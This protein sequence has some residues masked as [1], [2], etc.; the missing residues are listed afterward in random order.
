MNGNDL[1]VNNTP[2]YRREMKKN[3][4]FYFYIFKERS[5][6]MEVW[7]P[8]KN[9]PIYNGSSEGRII[10]IRTQKI[11]KPML[12]KNGSV[13]VHLYK[14]GKRHS[15][16]VRRVIAETFLGEHPGM[17]VRNKDG[18]PFNNSVDNLEWCTRSDLVKAAYERGSKKPRESRK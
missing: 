6:L 17:D 4:F 8:L 18:D 2:F 3:F 12:N 11:Q 5:N 15:V 13:K 10:N 16:K 1:R 9:F 7:K 14:N